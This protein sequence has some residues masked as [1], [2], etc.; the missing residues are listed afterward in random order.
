MTLTSNITYFKSKSLLDDYLFKKIENL[1]SLNTPANIIL[2]GGSSPV[3][4][5]ERI[6]DSFLSLKQYKFVLSDDRRV[7]IDDKLSNEGMLNRTLGKKG[8][9]HLLSLHSHDIEMQLQSIPYYDLAIL[10]MGLDGHFASIFPDM[11]NLDVALS[12]KHSI[13]FVNDGYPEVP[14]ITMTLNEINK[15]KEIILLIHGQEKLDLVLNLD[16]NSN[17]PIKNLISTT[18][19]KLLITTCA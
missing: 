11:T 2:S 4:L 14:R 13:E 15:A 8:D 10:G 16:R 7:K 9:L 6:G 1:G 12:A 5:Y 18:H 3:P 17:L 19:Q